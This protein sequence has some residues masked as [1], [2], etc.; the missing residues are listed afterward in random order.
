LSISF[1]F[2]FTALESS[3][4]CPTMLIEKAKQRERGRK[5]GVW[6]E[7][8][9]KSSG[10]G[11]NSNSNNVDTLSYWAKCASSCNPRA[12]C[13]LL[14]NVECTFSSSRCICCYMFSLFLLFVC[15]FD[16][17]VLWRV[18]FLFFDFFCVCVCVRAHACL[19]CCNGCLEWFW[20]S[21]CD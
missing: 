18:C 19:I 15:F 9:V 17:V 11:G 3:T 16:L 20:F 1:S 8:F 10:S 6:S 21:V 5:R 2:S 14:S 7:V 4:S 12:W 13:W